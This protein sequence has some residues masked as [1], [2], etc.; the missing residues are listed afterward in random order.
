MALPRLM[1]MLA[2]V[3]GAGIVGACGESDTVVAPS[4]SLST[5]AAAALETALDDEYHAEAIY[6]RVLADFGN[7]MPFFNVV[8]AEQR[9]SASLRAVYE[10]RGL[11]SPANRWDLGTVPTFATVPTACAAAVDAEVANIA[12][13]DRLLA[14]DLPADLRTVFVNNRAASVNNH[15]PAFLRCRGN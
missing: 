4:A 13:Y 5:A 3:A 14:L 12:L 11:T 2:L 6:L 1:R 9:H 10:R 8:V 15:Q 7:V